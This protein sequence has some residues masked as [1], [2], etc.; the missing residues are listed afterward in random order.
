M[1]CAKAAAEESFKQIR[2][3]SIKNA[4]L[5]MPFNPV[6]FLRFSAPFPFLLRL[7]KS[8]TV[9]AQIRI[10][11]PKSADPFIES[12]AV[13]LILLKLS[14]IL[15]QLFPRFTVNNSVKN[16]RVRNI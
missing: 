10:L 7:D 1:I 12:L 15:V 4:R 13:Y 2:Q 11:T 3:G 8:P 16:I 6:M 9:T 5:F 14:N